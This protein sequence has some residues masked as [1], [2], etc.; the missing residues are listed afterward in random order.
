MLEKTNRDGQLLRR[1]LLATLGMTVL[2]GCEDRAPEQTPQ[3]KVYRHA[4]DQATVD[5]DPAAAATIYSTF[6]VN[7]VYD[8]LFMYK[9]L[10]R[11]YALKPNLAA[12]LPEVSA[13]GLSYTIRLRRGV[14]FID[15]PAFD[16]GQG[17][18]VT[19]ADVVYSMMRHFDPATRSQG[20]W[21]WQGRIQGLDQW[22]AAGADYSKSVSGLELVD[23]H[24]LRIHLTRPYPQL[25]Y[26]LANAFSAV[27]PKEAVD[28]FGREFS[29]NPVGSGPF[30]LVS[31]DTSKAVLRA[32]EG[33]RSVPVDLAEEGFDPAVHG[34]L[35]IEAIAGRS[36]PFV[37]ELEFHF[38]PESSARWAAFRRGEVD[39]TLAPNEVL[40]LTLAQTS[41]PQMAEEL[42]TDYRMRVA[43]EPA[44][45]F[46]IF[47]MDSEGFGQHTDPLQNE[48]Q[49]A[50]R[51]AIIAGFDWQQ[52]NER[53]YFDLGE[54]FPGVIPPDVAEFDPNLSTD[55][56]IRDVDY[57]KRLLAE[58]GWTAENLP[59]LTFG[60][61][62]SITQRNIFEQFRSFM[63]DIGYPRDKVVLQQFATFGDLNRAWKRSEL[64]IINKGWG[65][66]YPDAENILQ[67]FYG[68]N[69]TPGSN[70]GNY[71]NDQYDLWYEKASVMQPGPERTELYRSMNRLLI[72]DCA[73]ITGLSRTQV[74]MWNR[75]AIAY[76]DR[77]MVG[78]F[79][80]R[81]VDV[82]ED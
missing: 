63:L 68:P 27:V 74:L 55:S 64:P 57:A 49:H 21:L 7:N 34:E 38:V 25:P 67:L 79:Y 28:H 48:R 46:N 20:A 36:P 19:A 45:L 10:A 29:R 50:L 41:P 71:Q 39:F 60:V 44:V 70:D 8:T 53:F 26:T 33:F 30:E 80:L 58:H 59:L 82:V 66:D 76:P 12:T 1:V 16:N 73:A 72:D 47:N 43:T 69:R 17:R 61:P 42:Q 3:L 2:L 9:Y 6:V 56:V 5:L 54:I 15:S 78:G 35:G 14:K 37:D 40:D 18:E 31:F 23:S 51:C 13:D 24:Q 11:P 65:L 81:F 52:H 4:M 75:R 62:G 22:A 32:N 77:A